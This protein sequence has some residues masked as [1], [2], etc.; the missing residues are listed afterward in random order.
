MVQCGEVHPDLM[1]T[2]GFQVDVEQTCRPEHLAGVVVGDAVPATLDNGELPVISSVAAD[3]GVDRPAGWVRMSLH[4]S[5][6]PLVHGALFERSLEHC[7]G[8]LGQRHHHHPG[9]S[10]VQTLHDALALM[11]T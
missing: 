11:D 1:G 7:V 3:R 6:I 8:P 10:D 4:H 2:T 5:V 9:G